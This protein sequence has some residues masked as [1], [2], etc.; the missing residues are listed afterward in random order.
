ML[1]GSTVI[2]HGLFSRADLN[3]RKARIIGWDVAPGKRWVVE[4]ERTGERVRIKQAN[5]RSDPVASNER[6]DGRNLLPN[7][8]FDA[9]HGGRDGGCPVCLV[10][11]A[12]V[13][14]RSTIALPCC[15]ARICETCLEQYGKS[16]AGVAKPCPL[17]R[18]ELLPSAEYMV[19]LLR[20]RAERGNASA[21]FELATC[22][23]DDTPFERGR[24]GTLQSA[25]GVNFNHVEAK[26]WY[27][28]AAW[29]GHRPAIWCV[30]WIYM[31]D[32][33]LKVM[34]CYG[35]YAIYIHCFC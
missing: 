19:S 34:Y 29:Q 8:L 2:I 5:L 22:Y 11:I 9:V 4:V 32:Y 10:A 16:T 24:P 3:G 25:G 15:G 33:G 21:Q 14:L 26:R 35:L 6:F 18:A 1:V 20:A 30:F 28:K 13:S 12:E 23:D 17:C 7:S 27:R 31:E